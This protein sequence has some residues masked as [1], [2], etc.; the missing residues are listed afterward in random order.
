MM[1]RLNRSL[2]RRYAAITLA[3]LI[4]FSSTP[5]VRS[6]AIAAA[7]RTIDIEI[8]LPTGGKPHVVLR[9]GEGLILPLPDRSLYGFIASVRESTTPP[10][11]VV[12]IWDAR[13]KSAVKLGEVEAV[14]GGPAVTSDTTP[15]FAI[16]ILR[17][18]PLT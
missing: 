18:T 6:G 5:I 17:I 7:M 8:K 4:V 16:R 14:L 13:K 15:Q 9:E 11:V 2:R 3:S 12:E 1:R 10:V